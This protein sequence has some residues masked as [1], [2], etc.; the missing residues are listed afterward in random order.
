MRISLLLLLMFC[1]FGFPLENPNRLTAYLL[2]YIATDYA[3]AV[4]GD[5]KVLDTFEYAEQV[6]FVQ[7]VVEKSKEALPLRDPAIQ[8]EFLELQRGVLEKRNPEEISRTA[9]ALAEKVVRLTQL[10]TEPVHK[11]D[12]SQGKL[13]FEQNCSQCHGLQGQGDGPASGNFDPPPTKF[14]DPKLKDSTPFHFFNVIRLGLPGTAMAAFDHLPEEEVWNIAYYV[15]QLRSGSSLGATDEMKAYLQKAQENLNL[16]KNAYQNGN[17]KLARD[18]SISAYLDGLEPIEPKLRLKD[19]RLTRELEKSLL[20]IRQSLDHQNASLEF[21]SLVDDASRLLS[22]ASE[23]ITGKESSPWFVFSVSFGI[24]IREAFEAALLLITLLGVVKSFGNKSAL[25][26][27]H[28]GWILA[29]GV[30]LLIWFASGWAIVISGAQRELLEGGISLFA[31]AILLY[32]GLWMHR[33]TEIGRWRD[34]IKEMVNLAKE[35]RNI[36]ILGFVAFM[37]VFRE[38]FE[39]VVFLRALLVESQ[40]HS[41]WSLGLGVSSALCLVLTLSWISVRW[42][43]RLPLRNLFQ[44]SSLIMFFLSFVLLGKGIHALQ[45]TGLIPVTDFGVSFQW[46]LMGLYPYYETLLAQGILVLIL[47][48]WNLWDKRNL[49]LKRTLTHQP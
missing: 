23:A 48:S 4:S 31:V 3:G 19:V 41:S 22:Q 27:V 13:S 35:K 11:V 24:F 16:A 29:L 42:S 44:V 6:D 30:G 38:V 18:L 7:K 28:L 15:H 17:T 8:K 37:G 26:A 40:T 9:K 43:A 12:L 2:N 10:N 34:F 21:Y 20:R 14:T 45:E 1:S 32:F 47:V 49:N 33:K 46:D 36:L 5:G 39:T 25:L